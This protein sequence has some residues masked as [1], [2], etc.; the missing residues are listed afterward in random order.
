M[1]GSPFNLAPYGQVGLMVDRTSS[2]RLYADLRVAQ[3]VLPV[4]VA[5][6]GVPRGAYPTELSGQIG[7]G[8]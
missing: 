8:W 2:M 3:N 1:P 6:L 5:S 4:R 7:I